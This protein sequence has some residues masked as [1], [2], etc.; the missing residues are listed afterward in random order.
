MLGHQLLRSGGPFRVAGGR[1]LLDDG[2]AVFRQG[3]DGLSVEGVFGDGLELLEG[4]RVEVEEGCARG[5]VG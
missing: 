5:A 4:G 2:Q 3:F 1:G